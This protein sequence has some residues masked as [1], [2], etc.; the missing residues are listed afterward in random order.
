MSLG[1]TE[2]HVVLFEDGG[3]GEYYN[4]ELKFL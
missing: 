4:D 3:S 1:S 2:K